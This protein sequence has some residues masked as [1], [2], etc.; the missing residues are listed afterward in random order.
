MQQQPTPKHI[1]GFEIDEACGELRKDGE[2]V[3]IRHQTLQLLCF[4][5]NNP[6][7][8]VSRLEL[9]EHLWGNSD[10]DFDQ[11]LNAAVRDLRKTLGDDG[12][13]PRIV[14]TVPR[15]GYRLAQA[16]SIGGFLQ[17]AK[18]VAMTVTALVVIALAANQL[19]ST[20]V[21]D[22]SQ[23]HDDRYI[24]ARA[25]LDAGDAARYT[26][27]IELLRSVVADSPDHADA[28][29]ALAKVYLYK[30]AAPDIALPKAKYAAERALAIDPEH[31]GALR[32]AAIVAVTW[33][34]DWPSAEKY[35]RQALQL[36]PGDAKSYHAFAPLLYLQGDIAGGEAIML[37]GL[38]IDPLSIILNADLVWY[39]TI[40]GKY[41][42]AIQ[43]CEL[44]SKVDPQSHPANTCALHPKILMGR[45]DEAA[46]IIRTTIQS[47]PDSEPLDMVSDAE[48][49]TR[50]WR[51]V[52]SALQNQQAAQYVDP[53]SFARMHAHLG[54]PDATLRALER[55]VEERSVFAPYIHLFPE[56]RGLHGQARFTALLAKI[57]LPMEPGV[58]L[59][60]L[61]QQGAG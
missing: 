46:A 17:P 52:L 55:A 23:V 37:K 41:T 59:A 39:Y 42:E 15:K 44:L 10:I 49:L 50:Y 8:T 58:M 24:E 21:V 29:A 45:I 20:N 9:A 54:D 27:V 22:T 7:R 11:R 19:N 35:L 60:R 61:R 33:D 2:L 6:R 13:N 51:A 1:A 38:A 57:G 48:V 28:W 40:S 31:V 4:L 18:I 3:K 53:V 5:A 43:V 56:F 32:H 36:A 34:R 16:K 30:N 25:M 12:R 14:Q 26:E 47:A